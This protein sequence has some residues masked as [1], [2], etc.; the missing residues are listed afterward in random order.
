MKKIFLW[1]FLLG[2]ICLSASAQSGTNSPYSQ[3]GLGVLSDQSQGF[4]RGMD[5]LGYG[6]RSG[7]YVN[8]LNPA[9]YSSVD[10]LTMLFDMGLSLQLTNFK[11]NGTKV[12]AKNANFEYAVAS[13]RLLPKFGLSAGVLPYTNIGYNYSFSEKIGSSSTTTVQSCHGEGG[14]HQ[15]F[16]GMGWNMFAGLSIGVNASYL[17]GSYHKTISVT[18]N[19]AK[20]NSITKGYK[21]SISSYKIDLGMQ[22]EQKVSKNDAFVIGATVGLGHKLGADAIVGISNVNSQ[23]GVVQSSAD[24]VTNAFSIPLTIGGGISYRHSNKWLIGFD[25]SLQKWGELD[26]PKINENTQQYLMTSGLLRDRS[27][28]TVGGEWTPKAYDSHNFL[29]R[30]HY[31]LGASYATPYYNIGNVKGPTELSVSAGFGIP[32]FN[33]WNNR[34]FLNLSAQWTHTSAKDLIV[35]NTFRINVGLTFN[36]RWFQKWKVK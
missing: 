35:E 9:S 10:S 25:Y 24:T 5:G 32:I 19:D 20:V 31:R 28:F 21:S 36:E 30:V 7:N 23:T 11:D 18:S 27:K 2:T 22:Y 1:S 33:A 17:W 29:N 34:S 13:F 6:L 26:F 8:V 4:N 15:A 14:I 12:N 16:V 3:Y